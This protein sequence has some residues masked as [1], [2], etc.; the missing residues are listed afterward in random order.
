MWR[1]DPK[2]HLEVA[3]KRNR[4]ARTHGECGARGYTKLEAIRRE[5]LPVLAA[6]VPHELRAEIEGD[7]ILAWVDSKLVWRGKLPAEARE[8]SGPVGL[9]SDNLS[10]ELTSVSVDARAGG[11]V[12][13]DLDCHD[14][15]D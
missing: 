12:D 15:A 4:G 14:E 10:F 9:R 2:P 6:G 1:L 13:L 3:L 5:K 11:K 8:L 7:A